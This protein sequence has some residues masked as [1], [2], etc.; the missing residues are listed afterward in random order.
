MLLM[1]TVPAAVIFLDLG[2]NVVCY[3]WYFNVVTSAAGEMTI[4]KISGVCS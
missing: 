2:K 4:S 3:I 1:C